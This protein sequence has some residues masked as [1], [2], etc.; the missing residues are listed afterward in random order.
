MSETK[1]PRPR[2]VL[3]AEFEGLSK[4]D[5]SQ[6]LRDAGGDLDRARALVKR[7]RANPDDT[8]DEEPAVKTAGPA[9]AADDEDE[10]ESDDDDDDDYDFDEWRNNP[11]GNKP[12]KYKSPRSLTKKKRGRRNAIK[13]RRRSGRRKEKRTSGPRTAVALEGREAKSTLASYAGKSVPILWGPA[14]LRDASCCTSNPSNG[15]NDYGEKHKRLHTF[16]IGNDII[17]WWAST[18]NKEAKLLRCRVRRDFAAH[19][20]APSTRLPYHHRAVESSCRGR[21]ARRV[22]RRRRRAGSSR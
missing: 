12:K 14:E 7:R 17:Q 13:K 20:E 10:E 11:Y 18:S 9:A 5:A 8:D 6:A 1:A 19:L 21:R 22:E 15:G 3:I 2:N 4:E 16:A